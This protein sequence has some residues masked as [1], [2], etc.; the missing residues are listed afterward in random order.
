[1]GERG[2]LCLDALFH[3]NGYETL[4][5]MIPQ[6]FEVW[7]FGVYG[8]YQDLARV[9]L[10]ARAPRHLNDLLEQK[11]GCAKVHAVQS[12]ICINDTNQSHVGE[13]V[14]L[15]QQLGAD[16]N[17]RG[18]SGALV[19]LELQFSLAPGTVAVNSDNGGSRENILQVLLQSLCAFAQRAYRR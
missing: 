10:P 17:I 9:V 14:P 12:L 13:V 3:C 11:F 4:I 8:L 5:V 15:C 16:E 1:M 6:K 18:T 2:D 19:E 7:M